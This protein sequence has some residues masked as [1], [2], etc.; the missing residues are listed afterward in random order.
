[1]Q[2]KLAKSFRVESSG[3]TSDVVRLFLNS[4]DCPRALTVWLLFSSGEH[5][6]LANLEC[7]P[8]SYIDSLTADAS[9]SATS[10][11]SK[12][13]DLSCTFDK[14]TVAF[15]KFLAMEKQCKE[16]N[17]RFRSYQQEL[18]P[19]VDAALLHATQRKISKILGEFCFEEVVQRSGWGPG[20]TTKLHGRDANSL[21]KFRQENEISP[22][23][24]H[25]VKDIFQGLYPLWWMS[26]SQHESAGCER[27]FSVVR[28]NTVITVPKNS[29]TDRVIAVE[30]GLNLWFQK[31]T[32]SVIRNKLRRAGVDLN[33]QERNQQLAQI[34]SITS[35]LATVDFSSASDTI[36]FETIA[37][38]ISDSRWLTWLCAL[39]SPEGVLDGDH[40]KWEKFS[41]MGNGFTFELES[42]VFYAAACAVCD[43]LGLPTTDVSVFG[44]DVILPTQAYHLYQD[45]CKFLGF[46]VNNQ[47]S[48]FS[49]NFRESCG[50]YFYLGVDIK[51][52]F[53]KK[54]LSDAKSLFKLANSIR[55][56]AHRRGSHN[57]CDRKLLDPWRYLY[58]RCPKPLRL[59]VPKS[60]GDVG[61]SSNLDEACP[62]LAADRNPGYEGYRF[63]ALLE[64]ARGL[65][66]DSPHLVTLSL[67][68]LEMKREASTELEG[69]ERG[70]QYF[71]RD[72]TRTVVKTVSVH[73][74]YNY[75][76]WS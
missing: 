23:L 6:Q 54:E 33:S 46:T 76:S 19:P 31:G 58:S 16:T 39:R 37:N 51:P 41:S 53:L 4:L 75:G 24:Y 30:P 42:L 5:D 69:P 44:D 56:L 72:L 59:R 21:N 10:F 11:L 61:F 1:M 63:Q 15:K 67:W 48:F 18:M 2:A 73:E 13:S 71:V 20:V 55:N 12:Y 25:L 50:S 26:S 8:N 34:G 43:Y 36:A 45:F 68:E 57:H 49:G 22:K 28:G 65:K 52:I 70:N 60:V 64:T 40:F 14:K 29:K 66:T 27:T 17:L 9:L 3:V 47:K 38:L 74:W 62:I 35:D 7:N 32:G